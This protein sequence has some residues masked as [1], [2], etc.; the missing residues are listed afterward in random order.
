MSEYLKFLATPMVCVIVFLASGLVLTRHAK[1]KSLRAAIGWYLASGALLILFLLSFNPVA[2][3]LVNTLESPYKPVTQADLEKTDIIVILTGGIKPVGSYQ[4]TAEASGTSYSR[5]F[6]GVE[7]FK[8]SHARL[9]VVA[10]LGYEGEAVSEAA[11]MKDLAI[12]LGVPPDMIITE[13]RSHTTME[14]IMELRKMGLFDK[15]T[16][17]G[18]VT[19]AIHMMRSVW[20][21][22]KAFP[23]IEI[24]PLPAEYLSDQKLFSFHKLVPSGDVF[25]NSTSVIHEWIGLLWYKLK[26]RK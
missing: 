2:N 8:K 5:I 6:N 23:D 25:V 21:L 13:E 17:V 15:N 3:L 11:V 4:R 19:S 24:V 26:L 14:S 22:Q 18:L 9:L 10:G 16:T 1:Q 7:M 12:K 20:T